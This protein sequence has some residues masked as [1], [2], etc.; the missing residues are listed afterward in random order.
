MIAVGSHVAAQ[1][2][3]T[4]RP[5]THPGTG[6]GTPW[7]DRPRSGWSTRSEVREHGRR[8]GGV[9]LQD[10]HAGDVSQRLGHQQTG[11]SSSPT[12]VPNKPR[13]PSTV[14]AARIGT[15]CTEAKPASGGGRHEPRPPPPPRPAR[16]PPRS[17]AR[18]RNSPGTAPGR[19]AAETTPDRGSSPRWQPSDATDRAAGSASSNP[20]AATSSSCAHCSVS[21][22]SSCQQHRSRRAD[23]PPP[24]RPRPG[25]EFHEVLGHDRL[26]SAP[27]A[28]DRQRNRC[29]T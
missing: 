13:A 14:P 12:P 6:R 27:V 5:R 25:R 21:S 17:A 23:C 1:Q 3:E 16:R 18:W 15:A 11:T 4:R 10:R 20:A 19:P 26:H 29:R 2:L 22:V 28:G 9:F 7:P 8:G 24:R